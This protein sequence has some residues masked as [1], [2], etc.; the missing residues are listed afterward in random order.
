MR[1]GASSLAVRVFDEELANVVARTF[2]YRAEGHVATRGTEL[3][4]IGLR[5]RLVL[6]LEGFGEG[7]VF[8]FSRGDGRFEAQRFAAFGFADGV[9]NRERDIVE[10]LRTAGAAVV[11][12]AHRAVEEVHEHVANVLDV[13]EVAHLCAVGVAEASFEEL[14]FAVFA[15]LEVLMEGNGRHAPLVLFVRA[16]D[17]EVAQADHGSAQVIEVVA[18]DLVKQE[19]RVAVDVER[20]LKAAVFNEFG[21]R[22]VG[23]GRGRIDEGNAKFLRPAVEVERVAVVVLHHV[24]AVLFHRVGAGALM[25]YGVRTRRR[26]GTHAGDEVALVE[27]VRNLAL[28]EIYELFTFFEV[29]DGDDVGDA[30]CIECEN[31]VAADEAGCARNE[32]AHRVKISEKEY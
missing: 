22:A 13:N 21:M 15:V 26:A 7:D 32:N 4:E 5:V 28:G 9:D 30:S 27:V 11:D 23:C 14:D 1:R 31:V 2:L 16:V 6:A 17:I 19:L 20:T 25:E 10:R 18:N 12:A 8:D 24:V 29:V 3:L